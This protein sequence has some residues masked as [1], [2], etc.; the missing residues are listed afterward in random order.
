MDFRHWESMI[1]RLN[2]LF[3]G[4]LLLAVQSVAQTSGTKPTQGVR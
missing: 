2:C 1:V 4:M 3:G